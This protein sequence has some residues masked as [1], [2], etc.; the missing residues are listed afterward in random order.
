M[1]TDEQFITLL[2]MIHNDKSSKTF[3]SFSWLL[4]WVDEAQRF[5]AS[6]SGSF[7]N[8]VL[9]LALAKQLPGNWVEIL[10]LRT[11]PRSLVTRWANLKPFVAVNE[12]Q[13]MALRAMATIFE[14]GLAIVAKTNPTL[15]AFPDAND[16]GE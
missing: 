13:I 9:S 11:E 8:R 16:N 12:L 1:L 15:L 5:A 10:S 14:E 7:P 3:L 6:T 4:N 2:P